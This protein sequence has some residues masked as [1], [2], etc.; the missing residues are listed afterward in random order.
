MEKTY[1]NKMNGRSDIRHGGNKRRLKT[2]QIYEN[3]NPIVE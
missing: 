3:K 1:V 2:L